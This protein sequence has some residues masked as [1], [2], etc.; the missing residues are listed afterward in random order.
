V[1][2]VHEVH[3]VVGKRAAAFEDAYRT[4]W[5]PVLA[6]GDDAR[7]LWYFDLAHGSG[8]SYRAVTV[9][10]VADGAAWA[11]L[12][13]RV[14]R[15]DLRSW[16]RRLDGLQHASRGRVMTTLGWSPSIGSLETVPT[17]PTE[18]E[19]TMYMEDTMWTFPGKLHDY[20]EAAGAVY[21][22]TIHAEDSRVGLEIALAL[23]TVPG[24]GHSPEVT[25]LQRLDRLA[26]LIHLLTNDLPDDVT[27]PGSWM[28]DALALRDQ[29]QSRLLRSAPWS[30]LP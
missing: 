25:L 18:H 29:W 12:A 24:A 17:E 13:E 2:F 27:G 28:H 14:A 21:R 6:A 23:Q 7:L 1:L 15:G 20:I 19:P 4:E 3:K 8:L 26:P 11:R 16:A 22:P 9:T 5:L 30:P 10:A